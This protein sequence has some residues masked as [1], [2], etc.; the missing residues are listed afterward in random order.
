MAA[1][2]CSH[3]ALAVAVHGVSGLYNGTLS[4]PAD[5][6]STNEFVPITPVFVLP[7]WVTVMLWPSKVI[8]AR[9]PFPLFA[10]NE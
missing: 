8:V 1:L 3:D 10:V 5:G 9:R 2:K 4:L 7:L 6:P